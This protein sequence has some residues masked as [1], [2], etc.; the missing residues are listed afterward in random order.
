MSD[1][2]YLLINMA[3]LERFDIQGWGRLVRSE[4]GDTLLDGAYIMGKDLDDVGLAVSCTNARAAAIVGGL[5]VSSRQKGK[6]RCKQVNK[7]PKSII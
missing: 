5:E 2:T 7:L 4:L 3:D 1:L 6:M